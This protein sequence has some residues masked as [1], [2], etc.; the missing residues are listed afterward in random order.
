MFIM[1]AFVLSAQSSTANVE[2]TA[3]AVK[4]FSVLIAATIL[5]G[6]FGN[7]FVFLNG[8]DRLHA[9]AASPAGLSLASAI[10][11]IAILGIAIS[12]E[13]PRATILRWGPVLLVLVYGLFLTGSRQPLAGLLACIALLVGLLARHKSKLTFIGAACAGGLLLGSVNWELI[14]P[15]L[16][17]LA[18]SVANADSIDQLLEIKEGSI[19]A[20]LSYIEAGVSS[21]VSD[22][23]IIGFGLNSFPQI[24]FQ[25]TGLANVAP[26]FDALQFFVEGGAIGLMAY[27]TLITLIF[28]RAINSNHLCA[29]LASV[30]YLVGCSMNNVLYYHSV[31]IMLILLYFHA[32]ADTQKLV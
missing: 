15:R 17:Y 2:V 32:R 14:A 12:G 11:V 21:V 27:L 1:T 7:D 4:T 23:P 29:L 28:Y 5:I 31:T 6:V 18:V 30:F 9:L 16:H 26:H 10:G 20:R 24:Y 19:M 22:S 8:Q 3:S 13:A 25:S